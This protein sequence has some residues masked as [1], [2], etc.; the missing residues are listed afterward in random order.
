M[1]R[2]LVEWGYIRLGASRACVARNTRVLM[3]RLHLACSGGLS[4]NVSTR[5]GLGVEIDP[6][7]TRHGMADGPF[8]SILDYIRYLINQMILANGHFARER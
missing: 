6:F 2:T 4:E 3:P 8:Y 1:P 7:H 5:E